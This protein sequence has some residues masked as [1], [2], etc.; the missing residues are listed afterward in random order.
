MVWPLEVMPLLHRVSKTVTPSFGLSGLGRAGNNNEDASD[1]VGVRVVLD[2]YVK[3]SSKNDVAARV[4]ASHNLE[5]A[6]NSPRVKRVTF[7]DTVVEKDDQAHDILD[8]I[9]AAAVVK[10][11]SL[12]HNIDSTLL[13]LSIGAAM[14][15]IENDDKNDNPSNEVHS[16]LAP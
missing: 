12:S 6:D 3:R 1:S 5:K 14:S 13:S 2:E 7:A 10:R 11:Q 8:D 9:N 16:P 4:V 15:S